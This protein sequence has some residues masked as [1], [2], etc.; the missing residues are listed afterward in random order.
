MPSDEQIPVDREKD[1]GVDLVKAYLVEMNALKGASG[2]PVMV[3]PTIRFM[4][5]ELDDNED[6]IAIAEAR[7][8][9]LGVWI[10]AWP[11]K[12]DKHLR[13]AK[14]LDSTAWIPVGMGIVVESQKII[15]ILK[16]NEELRH[17]VA[18]AIEK[19]LRFRTAKPTSAS[20]ESGPSTK[21]GNPSHKEDFTAMLGAAVKK[22]KQAK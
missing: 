19:E 13:Q 17:D 1:D 15:D 20:S 21:G 22:P 2:S 10:A 16:N 7:D 4:A 18:A 6:S 14:G 8:Y 12:A 3:R 5:H 11:G 9:L